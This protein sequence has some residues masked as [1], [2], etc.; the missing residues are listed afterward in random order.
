[1]ATIDRNI[2]PTKQEIETFLKEVD[3]NLPK[4]FMDFFKVSRPKIG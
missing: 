1:M 3:F 2:A 4:G